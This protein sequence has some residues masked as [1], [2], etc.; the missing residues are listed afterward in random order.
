ML[1]FGNRTEAVI[2]SELM[3]ICQRMQFTPEVIVAER[4]TWRYIIESSG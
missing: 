1:L 3:E 2:E 4:N